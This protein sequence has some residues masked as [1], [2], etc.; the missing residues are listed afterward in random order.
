LAIIS[1]TVPCKDLVPVVVDILV[2]KFRA[3]RRDREEDDE[4][5]SAA[6]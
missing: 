1:N 3:V 2:E 4:D 5:G 6:N